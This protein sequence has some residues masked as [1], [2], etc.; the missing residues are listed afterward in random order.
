MKKELLA[1]CF[2]FFLLLGNV[3][4][5]TPQTIL[6]KMITDVKAKPISRIVLPQNFGGEAPKV[7]VSQQAELSKKAIAISLL[8]EAILQNVQREIIYPLREMFQT[9][10]L[11]LK[12]ITNTKTKF[13]SITLTDAV[14]IDEATNISRVAWR[15]DQAKMNT[16]EFSE[17]FSKYLNKFTV[18]EFSDL[19]IFSTSTPLS[20]R[21]VKTSFPKL[22]NMETRLDLRGYDI[23]KN[24]IQVKGNL[25]IVVS[26][27]GDTQKWVI[28]DL[29]FVNGEELIAR[30]S[31]FSE[32]NLFVQTPEN[33]LRREA[34]RRG[35]YALAVNDINGDGHLD[36][37]VGH[38]GPIEIF[39]GAV[40]GKFKKIDNSALGIQNETLVKSVV[41]ADFDNNGT[42][43]IL[44][45]RFAPS[46][47]KGNDILLYQN[48]KGH[49]TKV[50]SIKNRLPAYY[51][52]PSA[53]A[54][55]NNDGL[56]DFYIG[57]P[58]AKDF[59][60]LNKTNVGFAGL[61]ELHP[62]GLFYNEG[63][64]SFNE[65]TKQKLPSS[66][67]SSPYKAGYPETALIFPHTSQGIDYDL[68]GD[69][70]IVVVDDKANLSP[71]YKNS[72]DGNFE[73]VADK[74]GVTNYDFG[75][76]FAAAD[77]DNDGTLE[78]VYTNVNFL[79]SERLHNNLVNNFSDY[80]HLPGTYGVRMFKTTNGKQYS[81]ITALSGVG[82]C[83]EGIGGVVPID[84]NNDGYMDLYVVNGLWSGTTRNEDLSSIF[85]RAYSTFNFD[86]QEV[87]GDSLG[88]E[89]ANTSFM[90][91]LM[92]FEGNVETGK[93]KKGSHPSMA[94]YQRNCLFKNNKNGTF[95][96]VGFL[97]GVD[98]IA[99]GYVA[100]AADLNKDGKMDLVLRNADPGVKEYRFPSVQVF[101]NKS[102][103]LF[104]S[105]EIS[106][107]GKKSNKS[108]IG[109]IAEG[110]VGAQKLTRHLV[111]NNGSVQTDFVLHFGLGRSEKMDEL[112][113]KW[114]SGAIDTFH[115]VQSGKYVIEEGFSKIEKLVSR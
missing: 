103:S 48:V 13:N 76:G 63:E 61:K 64:F 18:M 41:I 6:K 109:V 23:N 105:V 44:L 4:A 50:T 36:M 7:N 60:V 26:Q 35:G 47:E 74:I 90:K 84:Y 101:M 71:L 30:Q 80:S 78:F 11:D 22:F 16:A 98:S 66:K 81:D 15:I 53:V 113:I 99:D 72:G 45:V 34:I 3:F 14:A 100:G 38:M 110:I 20:E 87:L 75:M 67:S 55:F 46:E 114:P 85:V 79:P 104:K 56:L 83:G 93:E 32:Q 106:F 37:I 19:A 54:D 52:M 28:K 86:Y 5:T 96:D 68:D 1:S 31:S 82:N 8:D 69:M 10:T 43:D 17:N 107:V 40:D 94:G 49:F 39:M 95:T 24:K 27:V 88:I 89:E 73:Q 58:G 29:E 2:V 65:V 42:N 57:F 62:Q 21:T 112:K 97:E 92:G 12:K 70:D 33:Y 9:R 59:T 91:I 77:F 111:A 108:G 25:K 51:A 102:P 115:N